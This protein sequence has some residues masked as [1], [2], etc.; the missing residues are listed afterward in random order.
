[1]RTDKKKRG[2]KKKRGQATL[3]CKKGTGPWT[4]PLLKVACP[5]F[6]LV[7]TTPWPVSAHYDYKF[8]AKTPK[9]GQFESDISAKLSRGI[10]NIVYG[11][12]E[13]F[14]TPTDMAAETDK[15]FLTAA[16]LG[17]PYGILRV[18][19]RTLVGVYEVATCYAPQGPI[20][21]P[22]EGNIA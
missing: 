6:F 5:L 15:G 2:H 19:V 10:T 17:L 8:E 18:P 1:M 3:C 12:T 14:R 22:I 9:M 20:L 7:F 4:C 21:S 16:F 13:V 11:W